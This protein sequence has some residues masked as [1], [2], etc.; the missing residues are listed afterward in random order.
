MSMKKLHIVLEESGEDV[1]DLINI[2][3]TGSIKFLSKGIINEVSKKHFLK[4]SHYI[5]NEF[6]YSQGMSNSE[7]FD[8]VKKKLI[9][10]QKEIAYKRQ[11]NRTFDDFLNPK[12]KYDAVAFEVAFDILKKFEKRFLK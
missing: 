9:R 7:S 8:K 5:H 3:Y 11:L 12:D 6:F 10:I 1:Q 4:T 2:V